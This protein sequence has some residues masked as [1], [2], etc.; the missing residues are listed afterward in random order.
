MSTFAS[1][2]DFS[3]LRVLVID[4]DKLIR[5]LVAG[6]W[7]V[8][9]VQDIQ[10]EASAESGLDLLLRR[11][12]DLVISDFELDG[13]NGLELIHKLRR[14]PDSNN[15]YV[16]VIMM[17]AHADRPTV[18]KAR[19]AGVNA[20]VAK[21]VSHKALADKIKTVIL[22]DRKFVRSQRYVGPDRRR[23]DVDRSSDERR[24]DEED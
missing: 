15:P 12:F 7:D 19:D 4:D 6:F 17:T 9:G 22:E 2:I 5:Q 18:F 16:P 14:H 1:D 3:T 13:M 20:F 8:L 21:P 11:H 10:L 23:R 24:R